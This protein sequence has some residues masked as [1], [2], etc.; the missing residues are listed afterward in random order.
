MKR[1]VN[2][3]SLGWFVLVVVSAFCFGAVAQ[4]AVPGAFKHITVDGSFGDWAGVSVAYTASQGPAN[5]IQYENVYIANDQTNLFIRFTLYSPRTDAFANT[6]DNIFIDADNNPGTGFPVGGIGSEMLVQWGDGYQEK[7]GGFNETTINNLR[8]A[9][10]GSVDSTDFE[11]AISLRATYASDGTPV[12]ATNTLAILLEGDDTSYTSVEY[13]ANGGLVYTLALGSAP[14][15]LI[16]P[17]TQTAEAGATVHLTVDAAGEPPP[18]YQWYFNGTNLLG[19]TSCNLILTNLLLSES[20]TYTVVAI[21]DSGAVTSAPVTLNVIPAVERRPAARVKVMGEAGSMLNVD[22]VNL[23][24]AT[25]NWLLLDTVTLASTP[26]YYFDVTEPLPPQRFYRAWQA[27]TPSVLP[28]L[29]PLGMV[30][31]IT[32]TGSIGHSVRLD[33]INQFG[34]I[35]AWVTL[36]T[37]PLTNTSQLY[38]DTSDIGQPARL[39]RIV[40]VP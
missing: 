34:P 18:A 33:Y 30:P 6:Y 5:A 38:F 17:R 15:V 8:W 20:G 10:A 21:N 9:I 37:V 40:P 19:C 27:G 12:F 1:T 24:S 25:P 36:A 26:Q 29:S 2:R 13:V 7:H 35:D 32:L 11:L 31:A 23:L 3:R 4:T 28:S 22:Y 14:T 16:P 39:W